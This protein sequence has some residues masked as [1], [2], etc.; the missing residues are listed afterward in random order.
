MVGIS[1]VVMMRMICAVVVGNGLVSTVA[2]V[3]IS[4]SVMP[5]EMFDAAI[6]SGQQPKHHTARRHE[7]ESGVKFWRSRNHTICYNSIISLPSQLRFAGIA[8]CRTV[9][10]WPVIIGSVHCPS[11]VGHMWR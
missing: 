2:L 1:I 5:K 3:N 7:A 9:F 6:G 11:H 4:V 8:N 10:G